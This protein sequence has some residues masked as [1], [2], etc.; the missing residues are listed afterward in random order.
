MTVDEFNK[1]YPNR[2]RRLAEQARV[3]VCD[4]ITYTF[5]G[6]KG[7]T[8]RLRVMYDTD[9]RGEPERIRVTMEPRQTE[10]SLV[11]ILLSAFTLEEARIVRHAWTGPLDPDP[12]LI[13]K[14]QAEMAHAK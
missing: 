1:R 14:R 2:L 11:R 4:G 10:R 6:T 7:R 13:A 3:V 12:V 9:T 5:D 8:L